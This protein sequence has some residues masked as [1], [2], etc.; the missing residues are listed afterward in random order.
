MVAGGEVISQDELL[1]ED[2]RIPVCLEG[3]C[4]NDGLGMGFAVQHQPN[5]NIRPL[6]VE[7]ADVEQD[8]LRRRVTEM[9]TTIDAMLGANDVGVGASRDTLEA[10][11]MVAEDAGWMARIDEA[12][13]GGLTAEAAVQKVQNDIHAH[14]S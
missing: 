8:R 1:P 2:R 4:L 9:F 11:R 14:T 7:N 12:V 13:A 10:Y 5:V 6:V 3:V